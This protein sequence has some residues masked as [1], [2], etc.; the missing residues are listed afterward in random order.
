MV[1]AQNLNAVNRVFTL[2]KK[3]LRIT[4][5]EPQGCHPCS[6]FKNNLLKLEEK[7]QLE[8]VLLISKYFNNILPSIFDT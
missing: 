4:S 8:S 6:L 7:I 1:S 3:A 2:Q 5:F